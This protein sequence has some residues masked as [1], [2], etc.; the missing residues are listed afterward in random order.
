M[1]VPLR[2]WGT[3]EEEFS[4]MPKDRGTAA[5]SQATSTATMSMPKVRVSG[6]RSSASFSPL[7]NAEGGI[8]PTFFDGTYFSSTPDGSSTHNDTTNIRP[9]MGHS[10]PKWRYLYNTTLV[11][12][13]L[14]MTIVATYIVFLLRPF[15]YT[16]VQSIG[17]GEYGVFSFLLLTCV[18][19]LISLYSARSYERHTMGEAM[20]VRQAVERCVHRFHYAVHVGVPVPPQSSPVVEC[21]HSAGFTGVG[22]YRALD[23]APRAAPQPHEWRIQLSTV[24]IGSPE[25]IHRTV[26]QLRQCRGL[27]YAPI[28]VCPV[29]SVKNED[30]PDSAQHLVSVPFT[31]ANDA[32]ARLKVLPLNSHLPQTAKRM[33]ART[34]MVADVLTR[35]SETMRTLSLAVESMGIELAL[36][37]SVADLSGADL[38]FRNDPTMPVVTARLT[39]YSTVTRILKRVCDIVLSGIA[40]ILSSPIMLWVAYKVKREDGGPVFYSQTRIGIYGKP[41]TM[42]K[43]RSMR[44]DAD[45]IKAKLAKERGIEDRFIFKLKDDPRVTKIGHFIRK[46]SLDEFPQFFNVFKGD[47]SLVGPRPP[48]PEEVARYDMLYSTR[49]LVKP[50]ITGPWQI[51]GRSD[52]TQEQSEYADVSYIQDW[53]ITGD[54]VI[55]LKT[56]VAVFKGLDRTEFSLG[57]LKC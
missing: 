5:E 14:L 47:M 12:L 33:K 56:V 28:A 18:S 31:P 41:F 9:L 46:T 24:V 34:V 3:M 38:H 45:E 37:T 22:Y 57:M 30:D 21:V 13:D 10:V 27:G 54:I 40:I 50:G 20:P 2:F 29:A 8:A 42:Y 53:S 52:L 36:A 44:T 19:W 51:S 32:E 15:A 4:I 48:L 6:S 11:V 23:Y 39:Q 55:L 49:L 25:G 35:D 17:P 26:E 1:N 7:P 43:F 16:Y